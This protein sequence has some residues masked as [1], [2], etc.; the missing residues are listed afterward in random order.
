[1]KTDFFGALKTPVNFYLI[2]HGQSEGNAEK[3]MQGRGE[4]AL[5]ELG[6]TQAARRGLALKDT[7]AERPGKVLYFSSPM[8]RAKET[9]EIIGRET[10]LGQPEFIDDLKEMDLGA[11]GGKTWD[12]V[13]ADPLWNDFRLHSWD[14]IPGAETS[15]I[16]FARSLALW[17]EFRDRAAES[18]AGAVVVVTHGGLVQWLL[19]STMGVKSWFPLFPISN[20]GLFKF[21]V[22]PL[23]GQNAAYSSWD[24]INLRLPANASD[25][26]GT[27]G[28]PT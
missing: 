8:S 24:E 5:T 26:A 16:L 1:M 25:A 17:G 13:R 10:G 9:A 28:F 18:G 21:C 6:R 14:A 7:L 11:W 19:K 23:P 3:I 27:R 4:Y 15:G 22:E 20:C 12:Q 2:R